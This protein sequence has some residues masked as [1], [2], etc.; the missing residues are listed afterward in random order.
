MIIQMSW[1]GSDSK[2][3][4]GNQIFAFF[5]LK[6]I[7]SRFGCEIR[8]PAWLGD[9]VFDI[10]RSP[11]VLSFSDD[12]DIDLEQQINREKGP[13]VEFDFI[14][15]FFSKESKK[16]LE[17]KGA[18]QYHTSTYLKYRNLF[19]DTF[20]LNG[21]IENQ[22]DQSMNRLSLGQYHLVCIHIRRGD[23]LDFCNKHPLFWTCSIDAVFNS[24]YDL[25]LSSVKNIVIYL[26]S[27]DI[28]YCTQQFQLKGIPYITSLN[29]FSE[30]DQSTSLITDFI[31]MVKSDT[32][33]ISNS[34][35]SFSASMLNK[36]AHIFLRPSP[37]EDKFIAFDPWNSHVLLPKLPYSFSS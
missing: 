19:F 12:E 8:Y 18:F 4:L 11:P 15:S 30:L 14:E 7:Q 33:I 34:S 29:L 31:M 22:V 10:P 20:R 32:L 5:F 37:N 2:G 23:Y 21:Y 13:Q 35:L 26:C 1:L 6:L 27:D 28:L 25:S 36:N 3:R 17:L 9:A 24:I 16:I